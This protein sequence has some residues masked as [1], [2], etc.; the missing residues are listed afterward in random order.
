MESIFAKKN[1]TAKAGTFTDINRIVD[2]NSSKVN[3][4][5]C[6]YKTYKGLT[7]TRFP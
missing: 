6:S 2:T 3:G 1:V 7:N 5:T 4:E